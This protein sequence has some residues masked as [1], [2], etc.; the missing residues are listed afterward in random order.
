MENVIQEV[1]QDIFQVRVPL[2]FALNTVNCYLLKSEDGWTVLDTGLNT[3]QAQA[4]WRT[5]FET[6]SIGDIAQI[7]LTH[8]HPDHYGMAG[9]FQEAFGADIL[10]RLSP[11]ESELARLLWE[12]QQARAFDKFLVRCGLPTEMVTTVA[13]SLDETAR[14]TFPHPASFDLLMSGDTIKMGGRQFE[15]IHA[16]GHSDGQLLFYD[17]ND[18]LILSGDHVL[19][20]ITPNIGLWPDTQPDPLGRFLDSL[21]A[22]QSL[23]VRLALPG[24]KALITDW[25]GRIAEL[26]KH[27]E[28]RLNHALAAVVGGAT[29]YQASRSIFETARFSDHEWR[30]A[31]AETLAHLEYLRLRG[32]VRQSEDEVWRFWSV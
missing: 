3:P 31:V 27:H 22:L 10:V 21:R 9:W 28:E 7:V 6:L 25:K 1:A 29:V 16:P 4:V 14:R 15:I 11:R 20:K 30:F 2:P 13:T 23:E 8:V 32:K 12:G 18:R 19:M 5:V 24:H 17:R 26:L